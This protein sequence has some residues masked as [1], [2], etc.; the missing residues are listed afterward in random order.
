MD[1][2]LR[3]RYN[4]KDLPYLGDLEK[5]VSL[6]LVASD[7]TFTPPIPRQPNEIFVAGLQIVKPKELPKV[8]YF[9]ITNF[10][11]THQF[12]SIRN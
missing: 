3:D 10:Q 12:F 2:L 1:K 7:Y 4:Y 9:P 11:V 6:M 8:N 5:N